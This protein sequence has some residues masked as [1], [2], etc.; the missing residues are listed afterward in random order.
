MTKKDIFLSVLTGIFLGISLPNFFVPFCF[1]IGFYILFKFIADYPLKKVVIYSF[2]TGLVFSVISFYW[3]TYAISYYGGINLFLSSILFSLFVV[4]YSAGVFLPFAIA[5]K[6][7]YN[8]YGLNAVFTAPFVWVLLEFSREFFPFN[9][10]P[11]NLTGY[12]LSYINPFAQITAFFSV[13]G[14]SFM[15]LFSSVVFFLMFRVKEKKSIILATLTIFVF[16][17]IF[18]Y[19][20]FRIDNYRDIG[21]SVKVAVIQGNIDESLKLNPTPEIN[22]QVID[23]YT[24]L[25]EQS[26]RYNPDFIILPESAIPIYPYIDNSLK[27]YFFEK[28]KDIDV[29]IITGFD[30]VLLTPEMEVDKVYNS[31]FI[32]DENHR[33]VDYYNKIKLVPFG[34]YTPFK[35]KVLESVF[36]YLQG[37]DFTK[38]K[39]QKILHYR[40]LKVVSLICFE[41]IFP[42][43]VSDFVNK[44]GNLIVNVTNDGWFGKTS[45]PYQHFEMARIRSIETGRYFIRAANT[46]VSAVINPVGVIKS[47]IPLKERGFIVQT[48]YLYD[49][50]TFFTAYK[51]YIYF[52]FILMFLS[53]ITYF[54]LKYRK[55]KVE[56]K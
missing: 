31:V 15:V 43:F 18:I 14:I 4:S 6:L 38:G 28:I 42:D 44:G 48:V 29:P 47:H 26:L 46:G 1:L 7:L 10:F 53:L 17:T 33:Y 19:G 5:V 9:G 25:M 51:T 16:I 12:M 32:L 11:W 13:Y 49:E 21:K 8:R 27:D 24:E 37:I 35:S 40:D 2:I 23:T 20:Q 41:S 22:R 54:E 52:T 34:E 30:N 36:T 55:E 56:V 39:S 3:I 45:A 50:K